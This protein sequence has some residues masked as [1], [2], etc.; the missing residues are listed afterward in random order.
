VSFLLHVGATA[1]CPH[2]GQVSVIPSN[3]RVT[4]SG[5]PVATIGDQ[6]MIAGCSF[7]VGTVPQPCL[8][9]QWL[10]PATRVTVN[11]QPVIL[12]TSSGLCQGAAP[13]GPPNVIV[14]Q[15]RVSGT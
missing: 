2:G 1:I 13:Q 8:Q 9:V 7:V 6:F 4:V 12:Q 10:V 11:G 15:V 14:T 5:Q 3:T